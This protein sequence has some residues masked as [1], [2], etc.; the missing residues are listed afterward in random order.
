MK[1]PKIVGNLICQN[2]VQEILRAIDSIYPVVE[3][4]YIMD[5]GSTDGTWDILKRYQ[6]AY[7]LILNQHPFDRM[8][9]QRNRLL[10]ITP[11]DSWIVNIDQDERINIVCQFQLKKFI[12]HIHS[13][14][15]TD[16]RRVSPI[17]IGMPFYNL[18]MDPL[19]HSEHPVRMNGNKIFYHDRNLRF[20]QPYH[21]CIAYD[22]DDPHLQQFSAPYDWA[23]L[24]YAFLDEKR[25]VDA[26]NDILSGKRQY[27]INE[28]TMDNRPVYRLPDD[29]L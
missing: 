18:I 3:E 20:Y 1:I 8:D 22:P 25:L 5:G 2:G 23:I 12:G 24:H 27:G 26:K 21:S 28:W 16:P 7:N 13:D 6:K 19:H 15:Y 4:I 29:I 10:D 14:I 11:K 17:S 9:N